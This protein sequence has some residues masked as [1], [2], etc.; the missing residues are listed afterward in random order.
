VGSVGGDGGAIGDRVVAPDVVGVGEQRRAARGRRVGGAGGVV[1]RAV[2]ARGVGQVVVAGGA[3][4]VQ[5]DVAVDQRL[6]GADGRSAA[7]AAATAR[8]AGMDHVPLVHDLAVAGVDEVVHLGRIAVGLHAVEHDFIGQRRLGVA[9]EDHQVRTR[10]ALEAGAEIGAGIGDGAIGADRR[11]QR[12][13]RV[14]GQG[15]ADRL[16][17]ATA[18]VGDEV[19]T[20]HFQPA[21][22]S[23]EADM[24]VA[25][26]VDHGV[27]GNETVAGIA[28]HGRRIGVD[29]GEGASLGGGILDAG[30]GSGGEGHE[31]GA[32]QQLRGQRHVQ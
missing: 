17:R 14:R 26:G 24:L 19:A 32:G 8:L 21:E 2:A 22:A 11:T 29:V 12:G 16:Q 28:V 25:V 7:T 23:G 30:L 4:S 13:T 10:H 1:G 18:R 6:A 3:G 9:G 27:L 20:D 5:R 31:D 15:L